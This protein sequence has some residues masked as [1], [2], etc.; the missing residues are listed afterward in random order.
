MSLSV[1]TLAL[2]RKLIGKV[3]AD[4]AASAHLTK[5]VVTTLP[6]SASASNDVMYLY[7]NPNATG[8]D[9]YEEW[10]LINGKLTMIGDTSVDLADYAKTEDIEEN[11]LKNSNDT[12]YGT[13]T[14]KSGQS[15]DVDIVT[16][17]GYGIEGNND[18][19]I[20]KFNTVAASHFKE[21]GQFLENIYLAI[22]DY[23]PIL[24]GEDDGNGNVTLYVDKGITNGR[25]ASIEGNENTDAT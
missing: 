16:V 2:C 18:V 6:S 22:D 21:N 11:Y 4:G 8:E 15:P 12:F 24:E 3:A 1:E 19:T 14:F 13:L 9:V 10:M 20:S 5:E 23:D 25:S 17:S 7:K